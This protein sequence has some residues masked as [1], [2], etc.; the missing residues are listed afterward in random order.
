VSSAARCIRVNI[1]IIII[2][3]ENI[4]ERLRHSVYAGRITNAYNNITEMRFRIVFTPHRVER[5]ANFRLVNVLWRIRSNAVVRYLMANGFGVHESRYGGGCTGR[6]R[7]VYT[8]IQ[9]SL[10]CPPETPCI[11]VGHERFTG[12]KLWTPLKNYRFAFQYILYQCHQI[13]YDYYYYCNLSYY[14]IVC[15]I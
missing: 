11:S 5:P 2:I 9:T 4:F 8:D 12:R 6:V 1:I 3:I 7:R 10:Y 13:P 14:S 15:R